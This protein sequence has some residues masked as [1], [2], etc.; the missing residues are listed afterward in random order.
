VQP[1]AG[2]SPLAG[3]LQAVS[4]KATAKALQRLNWLKVIDDIPF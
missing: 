4:D 1:D 3:I 2:L